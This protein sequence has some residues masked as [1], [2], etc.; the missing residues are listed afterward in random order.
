MQHISDMSRRSGI[1][2]IEGILVFSF[3]ENS[4]LTI[5]C[6]F[7]FFWSLNCSNLQI[8]HLISDDLTFLGSVDMR[9]YLVVTNS[10]R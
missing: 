3:I 9:G 5:I 6:V 2:Y 4:I 7:I 8:I 1:V 10:E